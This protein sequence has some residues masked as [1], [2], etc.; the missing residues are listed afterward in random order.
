MPV[1]KQPVENVYGAVLGERWQYQRENGQVIIVTII[2]GKV[3]SI[4]SRAS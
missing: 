1:Y 3:A 2:D 4:E